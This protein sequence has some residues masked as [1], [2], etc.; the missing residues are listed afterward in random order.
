MPKLDKEL[1]AELIQLV[2]DYESESES[3]YLAVVEPRAKLRALVKGDS[4]DWYNDATRQWEPW[5]THYA[6]NKE[7]EEYNY[8]INFSQAWWQI[9]QSAVQTIGMPGAVFRPQNHRQ[10]TDKVAAAIGKQI[11]D[12]QRTVVDFRDLMMGMYRQL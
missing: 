4:A 12:Y 7:D 3:Q 11:I 1:A 6:Y 8:N 5:A 2:H 10:Q 9:L